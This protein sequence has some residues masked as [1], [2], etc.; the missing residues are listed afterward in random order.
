MR[1]TRPIPP[2]LASSLPHSHPRK[3]PAPPPPA[4]RTHPHNPDSNTRERTPAT[5]QTAAPF[6]LSLPSSRTLRIRRQHVEII[7]AIRLQHDQRVVCLHRRRRS[8]RDAA[9]HWMLRR[10]VIIDHQIRLS[11]AA[12][13]P[14]LQFRVVLQRF[15]HRFFCRRAIRPSGRRRNI[16]FLQPLQQFLIA[17]PH[18]LSQRV[19]AVLFVDLQISR[20]AMRRRTARLTLRRRCSRTRIRRRPSRTAATRRKA[21]ASKQHYRRE[22][23]KCNAAEGSRAF[24]A[25]HL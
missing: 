24:Q 1:Q 21:R 17:A 15:A 8:A 25:R 10:S 19:P 13:E 9:P 23:R 22:K 5:P 4:F 6:H 18:M 7:P 14:S 12:I 2:L 20:L 11:P 3:T 16:F